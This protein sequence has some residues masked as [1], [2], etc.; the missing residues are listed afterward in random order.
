M[1]GSRNRNY[2]G[3]GYMGSFGGY[4]RRSSREVTPREIL[5]SVIIVLVIIALGVLIVSSVK[6]GIEERNELYYKAVKIDNDAEMFKYAQKTDAGNALVYGVVKAVDTVSMPEIKGEFLYIER[7][8]E[9]YTMHTRT[10]TS[11]DS[12]GNTTTTTEIYY[13]WDY[14]GST[15]VK[16]ASVEIFDNIYSTSKFNFD[17]FLRTLEV[18]NSIF[19]KVQGFN[20][21]MNGY[22]YKDSD[23]RYYYK[24]VPVEFNANFLVSFK[25]YNINP[26]IGSKIS[27]EV[28]T[29]EQ[30]IESLEKSVSTAG[31][32]IWV[33]IIAIAIG[34]VVWFVSGY[35]HWLERD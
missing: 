2:N 22:I 29:I 15:S 34:V 32:V 20:K 27:F 31:I 25:N 12:E 14:A 26:V 16:S 33:V 10:V 35:H 3:F 19:N 24:Y 8:K 18:R 9:E 7:L 1:R 4:S 6:N 30:R 13:T 11:T 17:S 28:G 21:V 23:T 5:V